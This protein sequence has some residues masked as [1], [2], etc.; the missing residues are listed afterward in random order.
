MVQWICGLVDIAILVWLIL[1]LNITI[2][3]YNSFHKK[4][5]ITISYTKNLKGC[6]KKRSLKG[7]IKK[8]V[9]RESNEFMVK[10]KGIKWIKCNFDN[11]TNMKK[12]MRTRVLYIQLPWNGKW[13]RK[14]QIYC[15]NMTTLSNEDKY[16]REKGNKDACTVQ[17]PRNGNQLHKYQIYCTHAR[18]KNGKNITA[19]LTHSTR[20]SVHCSTH[21]FS[22][23]IRVNYNSALY[24][25]FKLLPILLFLINK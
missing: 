19:V 15:T 24:H 8:K 1:K 20:V 4:K 16:E 10:K 2:T 14:D 7:C 23:G 13:L 12:E 18:W 21:P 22:G 17:L 25:D 3:T 6:I 5:L 9:S 11:R